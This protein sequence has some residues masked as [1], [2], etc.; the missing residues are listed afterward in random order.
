LKSRHSPPP[1]FATSGRG[2]QPKEIEPGRWWPLATILNSIKGF[3]AR[4]IND[5][6]G[7]SGPVWL[8]ERF[9]RIVRDEA[10]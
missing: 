6:L 4:Q 5:L 7:R 8:D 2:L 9:D 1:N 10:S 3:T